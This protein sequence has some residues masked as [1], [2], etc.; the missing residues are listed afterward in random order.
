MAQEKDLKADEDALLLKVKSD[1]LRLL[2]FRPRSVKELRDRLKLKR[3]PAAAIDNALD[4]LS[5][6][7]LLNDEK[8]AKLFAESRVYSRPTGKRQLEIDLKKKGLPKE[9]VD[10]TLANLKDYDEKKA[11]RDLVFNRFQRMAGIPNEK[12]KARLFG[13]LKRRGF[14]NDAIFAALDELFS[15]GGGSA[16]GGK[17]NEENIF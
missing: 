3:Y 16:F 15:A 12:K 10:E 5:K 8:F 1:A 17:G 9:L 11:A 6:Q 4:I 13:F 14:A 7:G 2:S